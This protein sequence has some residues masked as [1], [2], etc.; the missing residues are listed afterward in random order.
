MPARHERAGLS[1]GGRVTTTF[2]SPAMIPPA[3]RR[4][5]P[6][7]AEKAFPS[8]GPHRASLSKAC[9]TTAVCQPGEAWCQGRS[10][11]VGGPKVGA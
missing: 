2:S 6:L 3:L 7:G 10:L 4:C 9:A 1:P 8:H 11:S 5:P